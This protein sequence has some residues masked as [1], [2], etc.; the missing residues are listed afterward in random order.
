MC[1]LGKKIAFKA[2]LQYLFQ[3]CMKPEIS[4]HIN[5]C[6]I[7]KSYFKRC[8]QQ[9]LNCQFYMLFSCRTL[10]NSKYPSGQKCPI[11]HL[12]DFSHILKQTSNDHSVLM[13]IHLSTNITLPSTANF[14]DMQYNTHTQNFVPRCIYTMV[15]LHNSRQTQA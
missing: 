13:S 2:Q 1:S 12:Q 4:E 8:L 15:V 11:V 5:H 7:K 3:Y 9:Y 14:S 6:H 10:F